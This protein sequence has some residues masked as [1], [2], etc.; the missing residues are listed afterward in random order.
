MKVSQIGLISKKL[1]KLNEQFPVQDMLVQTG[2]MEQ[3]TSGVYAY[4][5]IPFLVEKRINEII[6][7]GV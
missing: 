5:H 1:T 3:F 4:G 6:K 2:Q 7:W